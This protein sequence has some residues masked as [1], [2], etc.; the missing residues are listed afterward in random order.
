MK[1]IIDHLPVSSHA[2]ITDA[3]KTGCYQVY[4]AMTRTKAEDMRTLD[5]KS[6]ADMDG[7]LLQ[8]CVGFL[9]YDKVNF[10]TLVAKRKSEAKLR[11][12]FSTR[13]HHNLALMDLRGIIAE[14]DSLPWREDHLHFWQDMQVLYES[15]DGHDQ[16]EIDGFFKLLCNSDLAS[17]TKN[18]LMKVL[19]GE[20]DTRMFG[21]QAP[22]VASKYLESLIRVDAAE[23][24]FSMEAGDLRHADSPAHYFDHDLFDPWDGFPRSAKMS[25]KIN[26]FVEIGKFKTHNPGLRFS[27]F[28]AALNAAMNQTVGTEQQR[29]IK[30]HFMGEMLVCAQLKHK[31]IN[32]LSVYVPPEKG[33]ILTKNMLLDMVQEAEK[34]KG[35]NGA[36]DELLMSELGL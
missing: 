29:Q 2:S 24:L 23:G 18:H 19:A 15:L 11:D 28:E 8:A 4:D 33:L 27:T 5:L 26:Q 36:M 30:I 6:T 25:L 31:S 34:A 20:V 14:A 21:D 17:L 16:A 3:L 1:T 32:L 22:Y 9:T 12:V 7:E 35:F 13:Q 10:K